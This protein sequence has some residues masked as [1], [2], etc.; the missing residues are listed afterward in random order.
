MNPF[1]PGLILALAVWILPLA[2][3]LIPARSFSGMPSRVPQLSEWAPW[4]NSVG[5]PYFG[6]MFGWI[7]SRD[8]GLTGH[9]ATEWILGAAAAVILGIFLGR[10]SVRVSI[11]LGWGVVCDEARWTLFRAAA[12]PWVAHLPL[13]VAAALIAACAEFALGR[14]L[15]GE[16]LFDEVGLL[17]LVHTAGSSVLFLLAHNFFLAMVLYL[18]AVLASTPDL[19]LRIREMLAQFKK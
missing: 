10:V 12:W 5:L 8:F 15:G 4:I 16:K 11:A 7:S 17:F 1:L 19:W 2:V 3:R 9:T 13:A 14:K 6:L 18:T